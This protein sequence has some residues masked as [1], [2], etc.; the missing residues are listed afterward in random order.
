MDGTRRPASEQL[1]GLTMAAPRWSQPALICALPGCAKPVEQSGRGRSRSFCSPAHRA[2]ASRLARR[3]ELVEQATS[4]VR[5]LDEMT[6]WAVLNALPTSAL[7]ILARERP[8]ASE[9][10][11][12]T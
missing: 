8:G 4:T 2:A 11:N 5:A 1:V 9:R 12:R 7:V 6:L 10:V 3:A